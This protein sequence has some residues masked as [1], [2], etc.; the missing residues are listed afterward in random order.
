M[1]PTM[2]PPATSGP[3]HHEGALEPGPDQGLFVYAVVDADASAPSGLTGVDDSPVGLVTHG[4]VAAV[5]GVVDL[6]RP[7]GRKR[8]L[9]AYT[10]VVDALVA[11]ERTAI[12]VR[13][14][15]VM[16]DVRSVVED[17]LAPDEEYLAAE[18]AQLAGH[19]QLTVRASYREEVVLAE[20]VAE[21]PEIRELRERTRDLPEES[22]YG[23]RVRL[24]ELV[25]RAMERKRV[26]DGD[27]LLAEVLPFAAAHV[28]RP[29][30]RLE[31]V[32][33]V[34]MLVPDA[35]RDAL[36]E[37]LEVLAEAWHERMRLQLLGPMAPYDFAGGP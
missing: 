37:V 36:E 21:D 2:T 9:L 23:D 13:F 17:L 24:G 27:L 34:A 28:L 12:P 14:G 7:P 30:K 3:A 8:D 1:T 5:V 25:A 19:R 11:G 32:V 10:A 31:H 18:L 26:A 22:S 35:E 16:P 20:V 15:S 6:D 33:E 4:R 29:G